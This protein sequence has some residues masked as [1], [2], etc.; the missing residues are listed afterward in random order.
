MNLKFLSISLI[1]GAG[2]IQP[3]FSYSKELVDKVVAVVNT[4]AVLLSDVNKFSDRFKKQGSIDPSLLVDET[5][6][7]LK[8]DNKKQLEF[9]IREK[10]IQSEVKK[11]K[12]EI[13][14]DRLDSEMA[15]MA[16]RNNITKAQLESALINQGFSVE[17]YKKT[18]KAKLERQSFFESEIISKLRITDEDAY[19]E[20]LQKNPG[21]IPS[22]NEFTVAQIF[23]ANSSKSKKSSKDRALSVFEK[24]GK[25]G[26]TFE[27]LANSYSEVSGDHKD[28]FLGTFKAGEFIPEI[29]KVI[30]TAS[31]GEV[32][33]PIQSK[34]G[35]HIIKVLDKKNSQDPRFL[36]VKEQIKA[37]LVEKNFKRQ[38]KN[39]F[40]SK[41][42]DSYIK[43]Y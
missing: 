28:G 12:L 4:E 36:R 33:K 31:V 39:W 10:M 25:D 40:E 42:Q 24:M 1:F 5:E 43:I 41:K 3:A 2:L 35:F 27:T 23:F 19:N 29:E 13:G 16:K 38:L 15:T 22:L 34:Q 14:D 32:T 11:L 30:Q 9:L 26:Q 8:S 21:Y 20:F 37:Q 18:L 7:S 6:A 17:E